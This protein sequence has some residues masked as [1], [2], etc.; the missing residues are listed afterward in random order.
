LALDGQPC[1]I[2]AIRHH[3]YRTLGHHSRPPWHNV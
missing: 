1:A 3:H 2:L